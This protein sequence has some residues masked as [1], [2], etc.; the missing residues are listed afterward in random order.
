MAINR[1]SRNTLIVGL[2]A[3]VALAAV[4]ALIAFKSIKPA[5]DFSNVM[6]KDGFD[7]TELRA[8]AHEWRGPEIG[9]KVNLKRLKG[10]DARTLAD[11]VGEGPVMLV[12]VDPTCAMCKT[13]ADTLRDIRERMA[14]SGV[15]YYAVSF[16]PV[17]V[18]FHRYTDS[19]GVGRQS[20]LWS[21]EE[22]GPPDPL[23]K[24]VQ[25]THILIAQDDT[26]LRVW[27]GANDEKQIRDR[28][29]SQIV[30][31]T[32][33]IIDT[34]EV[35]SRGAKSNTAEKTESSNQAP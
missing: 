5:Q 8:P 15:A 29:G 19:L 31:D 7:F 12:G 13:A 3:G 4:A 6:R 25:P 30:A 16:V 14:S 27:P 1:S 11:A 26:V 21:S 22:G 28:M 2:A 32:G 35:L 10:P 33:V 17:E 18:D 23:L 20:F 24:A 34:L 9:E